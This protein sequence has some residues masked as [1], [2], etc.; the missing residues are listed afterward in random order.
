MKIVAFFV[1]KSFTFWKSIKK[2]QENLKF[3]LVVTSAG[4]E[5][6]TFRAEI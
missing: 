4:F 1:A 5:P 6:A 2:P 3:F